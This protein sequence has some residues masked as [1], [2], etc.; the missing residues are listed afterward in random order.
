MS[1][2]GWEQHEYI[3]KE[4]NA[5]PTALTESVFVSLLK[6]A[7]QG[8]NVATLDIPGAFLNAETDEDVNMLLKGPLAELMAK[9][10]QELYRKYITTT[11]GE[12]HLYVKV[13]K[14]V[15]VICSAL[16][17]YLKLHDESGSY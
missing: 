10:D 13:Q 15:Y 16:L 8:R 9:V 7:C 3:K 14:A 12:Q 17:L 1:S 4:D 11:K 6:E 2:D 5:F